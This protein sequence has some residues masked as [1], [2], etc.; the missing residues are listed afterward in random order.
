MV[1]EV[2]QEVLQG[3]HVADG[4]AVERRGDTTEP[5][6][7]FVDAAGLAPHPDADGAV[8]GVREDERALLGG[9]NED[10]LKGGH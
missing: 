4:P 10:V 8:E 9:H 3:R 2:G 7:A 1:R 6:G 5:V